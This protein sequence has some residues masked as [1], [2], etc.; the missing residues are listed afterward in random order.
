MIS[1][2]DTFTPDT[3]VSIASLVFYNSEQKDTKWGKQ[4]DHE[5]V[6]T[7]VAAL[8]GTSLFSEL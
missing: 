5:K 3:L 4:S 6:A 8:K 7:V 2:P 1:A